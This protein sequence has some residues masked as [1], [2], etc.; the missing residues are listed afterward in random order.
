MYG[1]NKIRNYK[2][3]DVEHKE[4]RKPI[5]YTGLSQYY[6][7]QGSSGKIVTNYD[8]EGYPTKQ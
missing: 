1:L 8:S 6:F 3:N 7:S 5:G 4:I 2:K